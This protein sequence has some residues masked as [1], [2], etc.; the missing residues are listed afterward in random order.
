MINALSRRLRAS[1]RDDAGVVLVFVILTMVVIALFVTAGLAYAVQ[2]QTYSRA[3]QD[4]GGA[5][6]AAR[7]GI[8]DLVSRLNRDDTYYTQFQPVG[9]TPKVDC[10]NT[11]ALKV[12]VCGQTTGGI[13]W[14]AVDP[15]QPTG[16]TF[17]YDVDASQAETTGAVSITSTG[18]VGKRTRTLNAV[19][20]KD[21]STD[22]L[23]YTDHENADPNDP[24]AYTSASGMAGACNDYWWGLSP[25]SPS[26][27][28]PARRKD[29]AA[30]TC[31]GE[32]SF[33]TDDVLD[34]AVFTNDTPGMVVNGAAKPT[35]QQGLLTGEPACTGS[36]QSDPTTWKLCDR[37][38][39]GAN[40]TSVGPKNSAQH[41]LVDSSA[42]F[43]GRPGCTYKGATRIQ[44]TG[45]TMTV[46]SR[47]T[48]SGTSTCGGASP[49]GVSVPVPDNGVVYVVADSFVRQCFGQEIDGTPSGGGY[50]NGTLPYG[51]FKG[52]RQGDYTYDRSFHNPDSTSSVLPPLVCGKANVF[53]QGTVTG[54]VTVAA[55]DNVVVTGSLT[56][57]TPTGRDMI[58]LVAGGTVA[59]AHPVVIT[60]SCSGGSLNCSYGTP[61]GSTS[62]G[63]GRRIDASI[64]ALRGRFFVQE[65]NIG[66]KQGLLTV[67]GSIAQKWRGRV[68][69]TDTSAAVVTGYAKDYRYDKRLRLRSPPYFPYW[70]NSQWVVRRSGEVTPQYVASA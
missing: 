67:Y 23:Y 68:A 12:G 24:T 14:Q 55:D 66:C 22:Y 20:A 42:S 36:V 5:V 64:Q 7:A 61:D 49:M 10:T 27:V 35:F 2:S 46:W 70:T 54:R 6:A 59:V 34:G 18:R 8:D 48:T 65:H 32:A 45:A 50:I 4:R 53:V 11:A 62:C 28:T 52:Y 3:D 63:V 21:N 17:H 44:F 37:T 41:Y 51:T 15:A 58:G 16:A 60:A 9:T 56:A 40:Y 39:V 19:L 43:L 57:T 29:V 38:G 25:D 26:G 31:A 69:T 33:A 1:T 13:G 47:G 30:G